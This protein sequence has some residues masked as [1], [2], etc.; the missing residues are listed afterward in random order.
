MGT[1]YIKYTWSIVNCATW[2]NIPAPSSCHSLVAFN[3]SSS[4]VGIAAD[5]VN[6]EFERIEIYLHNNY[7]LY[8]IATFTYLFPKSNDAAMSGMLDS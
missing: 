2:C 7:I 1:L 6:F 3:L 4:F 8:I 5:I